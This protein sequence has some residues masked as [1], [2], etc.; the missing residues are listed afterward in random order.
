MFQEMWE[1][2]LNWD[3]ELPPDLTREWQ[4]WCSELPQ[5]HQLTIP[6]WYRTDML[7]KNSHTLKLHVFCDASERANSAV[8]YLLSE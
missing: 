1:R 7:P 6:R 8:A 2:G 5:L 4:Q 3:E